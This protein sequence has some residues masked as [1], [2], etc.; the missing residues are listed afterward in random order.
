LGYGGGLL[1]FEKLVVNL[2]RPRVIDFSTLNGDV[3]RATVL[4]QLQI[5]F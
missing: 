2:K 5:C 1:E 3:L 4:A